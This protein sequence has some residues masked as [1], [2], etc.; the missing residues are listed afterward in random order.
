MMFKPITKEQIGAIHAALHKNNLLQYKAEIIEGTTNCRTEHCSGLSYY[1][2]YDL[3]KSLNQSGVGSRES[4]DNSPMLKKLFALCFEMGWITENTV[5]ED[6][7][8]ELRAVSYEKPTTN[9]NLK[10]KKDYSRVHAWVLK[11]G[12]LKK[13]FRLYTHNELPQLIS[14]LEFGPYKDFIS[15]LSK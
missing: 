14:Q 12:Y 7:S 6:M 13:P 5:V 15:N 4:G 10:T 1:E 2:A 9:Y 11:Y 8:H 3:L